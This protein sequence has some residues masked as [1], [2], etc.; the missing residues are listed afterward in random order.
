MPPNYVAL[1]SINLQ[2]TAVSHSAAA[3]Q[4][5]NTV[6]S[7]GLLC[8][9]VVELVAHHRITQYGAL[10]QVVNAEQLMVALLVPSDPHNTVKNDSAMT[11][12]NTSQ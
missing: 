9:N 10:L 11:G 3:A 7:W 8:A 1:C 6:L 2:K 12:T 4:E 5:I